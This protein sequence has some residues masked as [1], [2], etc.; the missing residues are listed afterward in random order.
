MT[1]PGPP[2][3]DERPLTGP[4]TGMGLPESGTQHAT[5]TDALPVDRFAAPDPDPLLSGGVTAESVSSTPPP[6]QPAASPLYDELV[7]PTGGEVVGVDEPAASDGG[8]LAKVKAFAAQRPA[9][10]LGA[11]LAAGLLV[12]RLLS[13]SDDDEES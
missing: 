9:A 11:T 13:S 8:A 3:G 1:N 10:F 7:S 2:G 6:A 4:E 12:G 5:S